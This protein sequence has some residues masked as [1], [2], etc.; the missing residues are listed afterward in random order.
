MTAAMVVF[1]MD[2]VLVD[3]SRTFRRALIETVRHFCGAE[4]TQD[5]IVRIKNEGGFNDDSH[6][7]LQVIRD[8]GVVVEDSEVRRFGRDL[9]WGRNGDGYIRDERWLASDG[10]LERLEQTRR[11]AIFT[12]RGMESAM[13]SLRRFC[14]GVRFDPI[15]THE[16]VPNLKPAPDGLLEI[17]RQ[18]PRSEMVYVG[19][20]VD[21]QRAAMAAGVRFI[22]IAA[23]G[24]PR[25]RETADLFRRRG[26]D[27]VLESVN[28]IED[29]L[30]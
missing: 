29:V 30:T 4:F 16:Q 12:G 28:Q 27:A 24:T 19:D 10:L 9:Y 13:H 1:D 20:N 18:A 5:D 23:P 2:G 26:A 17:A 21:D 7:A 8:A 3:P 11:L 15:I 25:Y 22:G 14:G 6:I